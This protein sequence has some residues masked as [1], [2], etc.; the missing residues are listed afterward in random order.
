MSE[1][2]KQKVE[3]TPEQ[4]A[5]MIARSEEVGVQ[6]A[7]KEY[8]VPW[9]VIAGMKR[10]ANA[11]DGG[12]ETPKAQKAKPG[13][14]AGKAKKMKATADDVPAENA[15]A[16]NTAEAALEAEPAENAAVLPE[17]GIPEPA[18]NEEVMLETETS[19]LTEIEPLK[20]ENAVLR[21]KIS[22]LELQVAK[23]KKSLQ[24]LL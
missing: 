1:K 14:K 6:Q 8:S 12:K 11:K 13:K 17:K 2:G 10:R 4:E 15:G 7:A 24:E 16:A 9:Q 3:Y 19:A 22:K 21:E 20:I 23:L 18:E 5:E